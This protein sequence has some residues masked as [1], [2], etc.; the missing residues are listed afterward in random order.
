M[1]LLKY[2]LEHNIL[3]LP[4]HF[5]IKVYLFYKNGIKCLVAN[6]GLSTGAMACSKLWLVYRCNGL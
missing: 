5:E 3:C 4:R 1:M 6:C 2:C